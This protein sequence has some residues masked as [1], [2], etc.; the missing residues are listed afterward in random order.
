M[1]RSV[2]AVA[3][4]RLRTASVPIIGVVFTKFDDKKLFGYTY[5]YGYGYGRTSEAKS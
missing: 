1:R 3:L 4:N 5:D 2:V